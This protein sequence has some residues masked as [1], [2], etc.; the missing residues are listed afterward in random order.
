MDTYRADPR[1]NGSVIVTKSVEETFTIA[2]IQEE[3][4][5]NTEFITNRQA[6]NVVLQ[7]KIDAASVALNLK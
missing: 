4:Q 5:I 7:A 1:N 2:Q 3:I 6:R